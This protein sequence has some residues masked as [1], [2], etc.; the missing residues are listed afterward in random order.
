MKT[1][2][3]TRRGDGAKTP[4]PGHEGRMEIGPT[5]SIGRKDETEPSTKW[6][7]LC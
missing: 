5:M 6:E 7:E 1:E 2:S 4:R 3:R